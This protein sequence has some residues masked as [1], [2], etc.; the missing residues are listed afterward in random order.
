[1]KKHEVMFDGTLDN[2]A[3]IE[4]KIGLLEGAKPYH[5]QPFSIPKIHK[6]S[7]KIEFNR[8]KKNIFVEMK[9]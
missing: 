9:K 7:L 5:A 2:Y 3:G 1:M 6:E 4:Y 8:S